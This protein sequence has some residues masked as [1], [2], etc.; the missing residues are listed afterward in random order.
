YSYDDKCLEEL[1]GPTKQLGD[2]R[3]PECDVDLAAFRRLRLGQQGVVVVGNLVHCLWLGP[4]IFRVPDALVV[5]VLVQTAQDL[6]SDRG[7]RQGTHPSEELDIMQ[8]Q[9][10]VGRHPFG[11]RLDGVAEEKVLRLDRSLAHLDDK[12]LLGR[13][14][15]EVMAQAL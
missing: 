3:Q 9:R 1:Q 14:L 6:C 10:N 8:R 13:R 4:Q 15:R 12:S 5:A 11:I 2:E 7:P